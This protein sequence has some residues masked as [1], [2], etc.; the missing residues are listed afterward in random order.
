MVI[1]MMVDFVTMLFAGSM[2]KKP[3]CKLRG[4]SVK[5]FSH[6]CRKKRL[7]F[8]EKLLDEGDLFD[9]ISFSRFS[10]HLLKSV[11]TSSYDVNANMT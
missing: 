8:T 4:F 5:T 11:D 9:Y 10:S 3:C 1:M 7:S 6:N 2:M